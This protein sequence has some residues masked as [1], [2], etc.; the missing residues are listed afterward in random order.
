MLPSSHKWLLLENDG[1]YKGMFNFVPRHLRVGAWSPVAWTFLACWPVGLI[2]FKP[3]LQIEAPTSAEPMW[4]DILVFL[5]CFG[6]FLRG[7]M[8]AHP[9]VFLLTYTGWSWLLLMVHSGLLIAASLFHTSAAA[10][11][12]QLREALC[13]PV[14]AGATITA[15]LWN[16][17]LFPLILYIK[18]SSKSRR[19]FLSFSFSLSMTSVHVCNV[20]LAYLSLRGSGSHTRTLGPTDLWLAVVVLY[21]YALVYVFILDRLGV[22]LYFMFS[23]RS[24]WCGF[25][26]AALLVCYVGCFRLWG[27]MI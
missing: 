23:P 21:C 9:F 8:R 11:A 16:F 22:H 25:S 7:S 10:I 5:W 1:S 15:V 18:Q 19:Q 24:H 14:A 20:P 12:M 3:P 13:F 6:I 27:G 4:S 2:V 17:I 26:Y